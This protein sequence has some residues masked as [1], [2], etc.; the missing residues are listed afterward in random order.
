M[1]EWDWEANEGLNP[2]EITCGS[3]KK[4]WWKCLICGKSWQARIVTRV[5]KFKQPGCRSCRAK[6]KYSKEGKQFDFNFEK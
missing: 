3:H 4:V 1:K 2:N 6:I 5:K